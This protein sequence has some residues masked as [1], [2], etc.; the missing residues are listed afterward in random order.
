MG[1]T[2]TKKKRPEK[3]PATVI[4]NTP[5]NPKNQGSPYCIE[6]VA[7]SEDPSRSRFG[8][9]RRTAEGHKTLPAA[10]VAANYKALILAKIASAPAIREEKAV[11]LWYVAADESGAVTRVPR[12]T[13]KD[14]VE[15]VV[16]SA[17]SR[18]TSAPKE[19]GGALIDR[20]LVEMPGPEVNDGQLW[21]ALEELIASETAGDGQATRDVNDV[22]A[23]LI[24]LRAG[25][26]IEHF[27]QLPAIG[28][29]HR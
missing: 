6:E 24:L 15:L 25:L 13:Y 8:P 3:K 2:A 20:C 4:T 19:T 17:R 27:D 21:D 18:F 29:E 11:K 23:A 22:V 10:T 26:K 5:R 1:K 12:G 9:L 28:Q 16:D 14:I 7:P